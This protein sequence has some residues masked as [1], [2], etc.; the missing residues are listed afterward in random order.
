M[1]N[2]FLF[3]C[4]FGDVLAQIAQTFIPYTFQSSPESTVTSKEAADVKSVDSSVPLTTNLWTEDGRHISKLITKLALIL[5]VFNACTGYALSTVG[6][7]YFTTAKDV[8][9][10]MKSTAPFLA[11][12]ALPHCTMLGC[13]GV[14]IVSQDLKFLSTIYFLTGSLFLLYQVRCFHLSLL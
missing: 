12:C 2:F 9:E 14:I 7:R 5:G 13:E 11:M 8:I 4:I 3:F 10:K 1:I 6:S